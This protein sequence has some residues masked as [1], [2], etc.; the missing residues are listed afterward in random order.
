MAGR[1][2]DAFFG[3]G[4]SG[5]STGGGGATEGPRE[6]VTV[7]ET[8]DPASGSVTKRTQINRRKESGPAFGQKDVLGLKSGDLEFLG[9]MFGVDSEEDIR[10]LYANFLLSNAMGEGTAG[11]ARLNAMTEPDK[12]EAGDPY[13]MSSSWRQSD[14]A[15]KMEAAQELFNSRNAKMKSIIDALTKSNHPLA[16]SIATKLGNDYQRTQARFIA[17]HPEVKDAYDRAD[18]QEDLLAGLDM[19]EDIDLDEDA[20]SALGDPDHSLWEQFQDPESG[21]FRL[22]SL[23]TGGLDLYGNEEDEIPDNPIDII[24]YLSGD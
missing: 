1:Y 20:L 11:M 6:E 18:Y 24:R 22:P 4:F 17:A 16:S 9:H 8:V 14:L 3:G 2:D 5:G 23:W 10:R 7:E 12:I 13:K 19:F 21:V 15:N